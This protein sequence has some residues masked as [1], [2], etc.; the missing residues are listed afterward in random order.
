MTQPA[1]RTRYAIVGTGSR[2]IMYVD[3]ICGSHASH[4]EL[5]ALCDTSSVRI[6]YHNQRLAGR[7][8]RGEVPGYDADAFGRMLAEQRPDVVIV[9]TVDAWHHQYVVAA[10]EHGCDVV[11]EKPMTTDDEKVAAILLAAERTGRR[12]RVT[13]NYRYSPAY[14]RLRQLVAEGAI[15][16]PFLVDFSWL[17][18]T[19]HGA[20]YFRRW[21]REKPLS[22]GLLVH[23]ASHHFDLVNWWIG[24][25]PQ[26]VFAMGSLSFYGRDAAARRGE[27]YAYSRYA[28]HAGADPFALDLERSEMLRGLYRDA[29]E[30]TGYMR[31]RNVFGD[32]ISIEDTMAVTARYRRGALLSYSL[33]A[34]SPWEGLRV[35]ITGDKGRVELYERHSAHVIERDPTGAGHADA[36]PARSIRLF[37][38]FS[39]PVDVEIPAGGP[40]AGDALMLEQIFDPGAPPDPDGRA[41]THLDGAAAVLLGTAANQSIASGVPVGLDQLHATL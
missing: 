21:H 29:E 36:G 4:A 7:F 37:P 13:F 22:G 1:H 6:A 15:G 23:K 24:D 25:W 32:N 12:V 16:V 28:G 39:A 19:S 9:T 27:T 8:D 17:L 40:H 34:Y 41:A 11:S 3:A 10:A 5:V 2:A 38:M 14:T 31:D 20:D 33:V 35:A 30:E 18:D 26:T